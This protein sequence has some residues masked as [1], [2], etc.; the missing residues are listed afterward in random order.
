MS[1][2]WPRDAAPQPLRNRRIRPA[3]GRASVPGSGA[4]P[5]PTAR[6]P[7]RQPPGGG[8]E[9][10][11]TDPTPAAGRPREGTGPQGG[12]WNNSVYLWPQRTRIKEH[13]LHRP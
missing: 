10:T 7:A 8:P 9:E 4:E 1:T 5:S 11:S 13:R 3:P 2:G 12:A 6:P